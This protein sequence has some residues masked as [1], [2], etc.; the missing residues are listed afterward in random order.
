[1]VPADAFLVFEEG[2]VGTSRAVGC[3]KVREFRIVKGM[4]E[5]V[6]LKACTHYVN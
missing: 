2:I 3:I 4:K 1:M 5:E 6:A